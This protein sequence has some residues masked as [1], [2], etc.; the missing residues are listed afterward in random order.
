M[1]KKRNKGSKEGVNHTYKPKDRT[2][3]GKPMEDVQHTTGIKMFKP[4]LNTV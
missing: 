4:V 1:D 2:L 3:K